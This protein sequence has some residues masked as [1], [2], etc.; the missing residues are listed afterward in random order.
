MLSI[1]IPVYNNEKTIRATLESITGQSY[2]D[3][4]LI[5][6]NDGSVDNTG[7]IVREFAEA[8]SRFVYI[9]QENGGVA[10][11][12]NRGLEAATRKYVMFADGDDLLPKEALKYM[13]QTAVIN[14]ADTIIG[15]L[16]KV[17][18]TYSHVIRRSAQLAKKS[19]K[20]SKDD[21]DIIYSWTLC[22][23]WLLRDIIESNNIRFERYRHLED[24]VFLYSYLANAEKIYSCRHIVYSYIKPLPAIG[25]TT[26]QMIDASLLN[27]AFAAFDRL[28][29][30]TKDWGEDFRRELLMRFVRAT[31][32]GDY[33]RRIWRFDDV[34]A[35]KLTDRINEC[36]SQ[37]DADRMAIISEKYFDIVKESDIEKDISSTA[38]DG[39]ISLASGVK[40]K[41]E[42]LKEPLIDIVLKEGISERIL[43]GLLDGIYD[44]FEV[45]FDVIAD[46]SLKD[47]AGGAFD[48]ADN[49]KWITGDKIINEV[50]KSPAKYAVFIDGDILLDHMSLYNMICILEQRPGISMV[51]AGI[52][53]YDGETI[54]R[55]GLSDYILKNHE[56]AL[57][58][59]Y[60]N[61]VLRKSA[62]LLEKIRSGA[63]A[64]ELLDEYQYVMTDETRVIACMDEEELLAYAGSGEAKDRYKETAGLKT[65]AAKTDSNKPSG[66]GGIKS[67]LKKLIGGK[68]PAEK[69]KK[70]TSSQKN[71]EK[72]EPKKAKPKKPSAS[73]CYLN[74]DIKKG[75]VVVEGLGKRP[76]G[77]SLYI[78]RELTSGSY[79]DPE[80]VF[81]VK[82]DTRALTEEIFAREG[83][84]GIRIVETGTYEYREA[85]FSAEFLFNE[86]GFPIWWIKKPG[87]IYVN[88]WHGTPI[89]K[90]GKAKPGR[91]SGDAGAVHDFTMADYMLMPG[92]YCI[93]HILGDTD[94]I[95]MTHA[96][97]LMLGYPR[98]GA[99]FDDKMRQ[100]VRDE[101]GLQDKTV[102]IWM[103][104]WNDDQDA[105]SIRSFLTE[106][107]AGLTDDQL[108]YVH[109][110]HR[111][112]IDLGSLSL[113]RVRSFPD[114]YDTYEF[115][116]A[117]DVLITDYSSI[118]FDFA[119]T[120]RKIILHCPDKDQYKASRGL[121]LEPESLPFPVT[122]DTESL[123]K[124]IGSPKAYD[125]REFL[126]TFNR[127]DGA[128]NA[129]L[130]CDAVIRRDASAAEIR[131]FQVN[132]NASI[133]IF[134]SFREGPVADWL[135]ELC[136]SGRFGSDLWLSFPDKALSE[137]IPEG[138]ETDRAAIE[139]ADRVDSLL[140]SVNIYATKGEPKRGIVELRRMYGAVSPQHFALIDPY[141]S[142]RIHTFCR[143]DIPV[144][145]VLT[146]RQMDL[147]R[148]G[149][150][151]MTDAVTRFR[152][153]GSGIWTLDKDDSIWLS[154]NLG[155]NAG[156]VTSAEEFLDAILRR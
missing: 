65:N 151:D 62:V 47:A 64:A 119:V 135:F 67:L 86:V 16:N 143:C 72:P 94:M 128:D 90:L 154:D 70:E 118:F 99:L 97:G 132:E 146:D 105:D 15:I 12:R 37:L 113:E 73:D 26:T 141:D 75:R 9:E 87:Q 95:G 59:L 82:D 24:A 100:K 63:S 136:G 20:V 129:K 98:T 122:C 45:A 126:D 140:R 56:E 117:A 7:D 41:S 108:M 144:K 5:V 110:H 156:T 96:K 21:P 58:A 60:A 116:T 10:A 79:G 18:G 93:E 27:S 57:D 39:Q 109:L 22:N 14:D 30:I 6:V 35:A 51:S 29:D 2:G 83:F 77:S 84:N 33:Y 138:S 53:L 49:L 46:E 102:S 111:T 80:I 71:T 11:A 17:D 139:R 19:I 44:Q 106:V 124:E 107:D 48:F 76:V 148:S 88:L 81:P 69:A 68:Q 131:D 50:A 1:I 103:P 78:L 115:L 123:L 101:Y 85:L 52:D 142:Q 4:E 112:G 54:R 34:T 153:F 25:R 104:T 43:P 145:L 150:D 3:F 91:V 114:K 28:S 32:I 38:D 120:R 31:L 133:I 130:L 125:D 13:H 149:D 137:I 55:S 152:R 121:Y 66:S 155:I 134:D 8:D 23:K 42:L 74:L 147:L 89:K 40:T 61:K 92:D 36:C 127:Y